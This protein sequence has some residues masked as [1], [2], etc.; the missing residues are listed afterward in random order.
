MNNKK[1][2]NSRFISPASLLPFILVTTLFFMWGIPNN[3]NGVLI[4]QF[5]KS[6]ELTAFKAGLIQSA[7]YMGYFI[8]AVPA[9]ILMRKYSYKVGIVFGLL[10]YA[11]GCL[12]FYPA[13]LIGTYGFFLFALFIIASGLAFLET[14]ANPFIALLGNKDSSERRLNL[15]QAFNPIGSVVGVVL[16]TAFI[17]SGVEPDE[18][19]ITALKAAGEY[20][21]FLQ[22]ETLRVVKPYLALAAFAVVWALLII[23][24]KFPHFKEEEKEPSKDNGRL[25]ELF[26]LPHFIKGVIAQFFYVGAQ[27]GTWSYF[28]MYVQDYTGEAEKMAGYLLT[29]TLI[30]FGAGRFSATWI[31]R[32]VAPAKL[33]GVYSIINL[34]LVAIS[35]TMPGWIGMWALFFTSFFMSLMYPTIFAMSIKGLGPNTK[36]GG[37]VLVMAIIGGAILTP[38]M[39]LIAEETESMALAM[40]I[41]L[42]AYVYIAYYSWFGAKTV[43]TSIPEEEK[44]LSFSR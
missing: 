34:I 1:E 39:G 9:A 14:G 18:S 41:P 6:F 13:A 27:V 24:T 5:M 30:A 35:I 7:F 23:R 4:K 44:K 25:T 2:K 29:G 37:S 12:L 28:I 38:V 19:K 31:M 40:M 42:V 16:G 26:K 11:F 10:L 36:I 32:V 33:M 21:A 15:S 8:L 17:F 3:L 22:H 43:T 20:D